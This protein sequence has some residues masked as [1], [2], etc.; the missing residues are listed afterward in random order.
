MKNKIITSILYL[1]LGIVFAY[2]S[3]LCASWISIHENVNTTN[4]TLMQL[5]NYRFMFAGNFIGSFVL[6]LGGLGCLALILETFF[7][8]ITNE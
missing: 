5:T 8:K 2:I 4:Y 7:G 3:L 6:A 1:F